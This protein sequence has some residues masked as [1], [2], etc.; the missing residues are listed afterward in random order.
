MKIIKRLL[1][2]SAILVCLSTISYFIWVCKANYAIPILT[3]HSIGYKKDALFVT[4]ENLDRQLAYLKNN[5]YHV[6]SLDE[7]AE[8][9]KKNKIFD[10]RTVI[11]TFDDGRKDNYQYAYPALKKYHFPATIFLAAN[12]INNKE[13]FLAW[14]EV[15]T[16]QKDGISFG[17]HTK[18][19]VHL[20]STKS[21]ETLWDE[22]AG[23][24]KMI[25]QNI[26][27]PVYYFSYP[28]GGFNENVKS[29]VKKAGFKGACTT[30][31][32]PSRSNQ[33]VY[34]LK[35]IRVKDADMNKPF[36]FWAKLSGY[37]NIFRRQR[38][39]VEP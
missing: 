11:I 1:I 3:Y 14:D 21:D 32:G 13:G 16:M 8:G 15:R 19:H 37:Y 6:I 25:E 22:I 34:A 23:A 2:I 36:T 9:V 27:I 33:D 20:D 30:N 39:E 31:I 7:L 4:P 18:N 28:Y 5:G 24:K 35:R 29:I 38:L 17:A 12:L 26:N 10:N